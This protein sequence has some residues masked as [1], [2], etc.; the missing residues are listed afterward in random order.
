VRELGENYNLT[1]RERDVLRELVKGH[2]YKIIAHD[3]GVTYDTVRMHIKH[4][5]SKMGVGSISGAVA[6]ALKQNIVS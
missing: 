3:L 4:I 1:A 5:Y 6:K 2:S